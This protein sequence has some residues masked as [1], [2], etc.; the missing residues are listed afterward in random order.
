MSIIHI[1]GEPEKQEK[2]R[3]MTLF[4]EIMANNFPDLMT[5]DNPQI[6]IVSKHL[7]G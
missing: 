4:E 1:T 2:T 7:A 3:T 6:Q 5:E